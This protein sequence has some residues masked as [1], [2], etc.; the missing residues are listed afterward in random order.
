MEIRCPKCGGP[1]I[2]HFSPAE[3]KKA[4]ENNKQLKLHCFNCGD[5]VDN[6]T[7]SR[8]GMEEALSLSSHG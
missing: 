5:K 4:Q 6:W 1:P 7:L 3:L 2:E 8:Q